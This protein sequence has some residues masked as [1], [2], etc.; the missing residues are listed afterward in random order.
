MA[1]HTTESPVTQGNLLIVTP[2]KVK[3]TK[4]ITYSGI[5]HTLLPL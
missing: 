5:E 4:Q 2:Y 3:V 1:F